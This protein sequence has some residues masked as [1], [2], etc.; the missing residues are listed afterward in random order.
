M[1]GRLYHEEFINKISESANPTLEDAKITHIMNR[2]VDSHVIIRECV[3]DYPFTKNQFI[4]AELGRT[5]SKKGDLCRNLSKWAEQRLEDGTI[6]L[7]LNN[8]GNRIN[9]WLNTSDILLEN[10]R[11]YWK[12]FKSGNKNKI[13]THAE[14]ELFKLFETLEEISVLYVNN[15]KKLESKNG[16]CLLKKTSF[17]LCSA[18]MKRESELLKIASEVSCLNIY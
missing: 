5:I 11:K 2:I 18:L 8:L 4:D 3:G 10:A 13:I 1:S 17:D 14:S 12:W 15:M 16:V 9:Y 6:I 7:I